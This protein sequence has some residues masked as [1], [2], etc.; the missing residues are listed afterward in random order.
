MMSCTVLFWKMR[1]QLDNTIYAAEK[2]LRENREK[3]GEANVKPAEE[4]V[5]EAKKALNEGDTARLR[6][7]RE[8]LERSLHKIA[9]ELYR[10]GAAAGAP[11][12]SEATDRGT[13]TSGGAKPSGGKGQGD[14]IDA[15]YVDV[16][17]TKK[18]N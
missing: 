16:D 4:A 15:E 14:V 1:N 13:D 8:N 10:T 2:M 17:D 6:S 7:A 3:L 9:E 12:Q 11:G 18:P 5:A